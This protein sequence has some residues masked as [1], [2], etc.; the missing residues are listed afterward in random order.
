MGAINLES[1]WGTKC[2]NVF[3]MAAEDLLVQRSEKAGL[4]VATEN[5]VTIALDT[6]LTAEL[7]A[8]GLAREI[9]SKVQ[10]L[11]KESNLE[12]V[13]RIKLSIAGDEAVAAAANNFAD[14][15]KNEVLAV[16]MTV[17]GGSGDVDLNGHKAALSLSKA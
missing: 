2:T 10:N 8:E 17:A 11:R 9:V 1:D 12:V 14:Y 5:G 7:E 15:I 13:D 4:V 16:E 6:A 3:A